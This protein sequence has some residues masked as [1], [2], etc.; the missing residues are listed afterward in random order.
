MYLLA[1]TFAIRDAIQQQQIMLQLAPQ[2]GLVCQLLPQL[3]VLCLHALDTHALLRQPP[4]KQL[5]HS[6]QE[7]SLS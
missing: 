5:H 4:R 2:G 6:K 7:S 3:L 1:T